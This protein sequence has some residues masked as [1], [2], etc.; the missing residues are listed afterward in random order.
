ML[1]CFC[2]E[3]QRDWDEGVPLALFA[4][5]EIV[6]E[7]LGFSPSELVFGHT[8]CGHLKLLKE[9]WLVEPKECLSLSDY[10]S[11]MR[12]RLSRACQLAKDNLGLCQ[13]RMKQRFDQRAVSRSFSPGDKVLVL[14]PVMGS[15]LQAR[16]SGPY[17][18][19]RRVNDL[20][21]VISTPDRRRKTTLCHINRLKLYC[22]RG[23]GSISELK[24]PCTST[25]IN[26]DAH[27]TEVVLS[28]KYGAE[29]VS[30]LV[31]TA[32]AENAPLSV[33]QGVVASALLEDE[34]RVPSVEVIE[35]RMK[36][37]EILNDLD[38]FL[39]SLSTLERNDLISLIKQ[40]ES[41]FPDVPHRTMVIEHDIDVGAT[42]P[43]KQHPYR[44]NP[45]KRLLLQNEVNFMLKNGIAESSNS[46]WSSPCLLVPKSDGFMRFCTDFRRVNAITKPDS[47]PLPRIDD[48]VD[49]LGSAVFVS[50]I[51]LLK[52]YWQ[53]PL[54]F[55]AK[56]ISAFVTPDHFL[57][58]TAI[59]FGL[60]NA[61]ATFQRLI[62]GVLDGV[63]N[64]E[65]YLDDL[66][67]HSATWPLHMA[68]L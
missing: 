37:S 1:K 59:A 22:D 31:V 19:E 49:R 16:Y 64:C 30:S 62:N 4:V 29:V 7:S 58:Y 68:H 2:L 43:I 18:V 9:S 33:Q 56:E 11:N 54:T 44:T 39:S 20:N 32:Q 46:P 38:S 5:R 45:H 51:D 24:S 35:G 21:Y 8:V 48:C 66:V 41:L 65:A 27:V 17:R 25:V 40:H 36:N 61:P 12:N 52:G 6:Q 57:Q 28:K 26:D 53:I 14:L 60:R 15:A 23:E 47:Y 42:C 3:F 10:V 34:G 13:K 50:K 63:P 67:I 55:R